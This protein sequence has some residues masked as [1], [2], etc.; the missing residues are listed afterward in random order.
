MIEYQDLTRT[1]LAKGKWQKNRTGIRTLMIPGAMFQVDMSTYF[2]AVTTKRLAF[3]NVKGELRAFLRGCDTA[4]QFRELGCGVWDANSSAP[5]W[6]ESV[7]YKR[8]IDA[9]GCEEDGYLG[10]VYGKQ[11]TEWRTATGGVLNQIDAL[12]SSILQDPTS[13]RM[14]VT[15]WRPDEI[16]QMALPPCHYGFQVIIEQETHTM[17]LLWNQRSVDT[18]LGLPFNI[19]SYALLLSALA[20][21]TGY[22]VGTMTGFLA[23]VHLYEN[24]MEQVELQQSRTP[25]ALP[26]LYVSKD[27]AS[28]SD[29]TQLVDSDMQLINYKCHDAIKADMAV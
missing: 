9:G 15:A 16:N 4:K 7:E 19:A 6:M 29:L 3:K 20:A 24:H 26:K 14:L 5:K 23:D 25:L 21:K 13:R 18:F 12:I 1:I 28:Y 22:N 8:W 10:R 2:P 27:I 11:W 17:H